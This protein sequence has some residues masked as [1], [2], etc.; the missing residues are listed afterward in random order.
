MQYKTEY[1]SMK[2][3]FWWS[4]L[5][6]IK[7]H[8]GG[9]DGHIKQRAELPFLQCL[10]M[11]RRYGRGIICKLGRIRKSCMRWT[12][13][14][15]TELCLFAFGHSS[16]VRERDKTG[17]LMLGSDQYLALQQWAQKE[18]WTCV[19]LPFLLSVMDH[20][21]NNDFLDCGRP[22]FATTSRAAN[23]SIL[24]MI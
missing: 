11:G 5:L 15:S 17:T 9:W 6:L 2:Y 1:I 13:S 18:L 7:Q 12:F 14:S 23:P 10:H 8:S 3:H 19:T 24:F 16:N 4:S 22:C 21:L 20:E